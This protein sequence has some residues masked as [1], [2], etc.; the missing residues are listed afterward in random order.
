MDGFKLLGKADGWHGRIPMR[1]D[2]DDGAGQRQG[3]RLGDQRGAGCARTQRE[4]G[5]AMR[6]EEGRLDRVHDSTPFAMG[7]LY[8]RF[9]VRN[10]GQLTNHY[11]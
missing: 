7:L 4:G 10:R 11:C 9:L 3:G 5:R 8:A 1:A 2:H 6:D